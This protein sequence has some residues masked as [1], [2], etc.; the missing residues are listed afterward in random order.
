MVTQ[1]FSEV[2]VH[3]AQDDKLAKEIN[4]THHANSGGTLSHP[5]LTGY[6]RIDHLKISNTSNSLAVDSCRIR[7]VKGRDDHL[8]FFRKGDLFYETI[9]Y[10]FYMCFL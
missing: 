3:G 4:F 5:D 2:M 8:I 10:K 1:P 6:Q 9:P 7:V